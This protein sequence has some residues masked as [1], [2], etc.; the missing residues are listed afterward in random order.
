MRS[1][2]LAAAALTAVSVT[3]FRG[4]IN[5]VPFDLV[6]W[7]VALGCAAW[8][9]WDWRHH[10]SRISERAALCAV[11]ALVLLIVVLPM[12]AQMTLRAHTD[13]ALF[14]HDGALQ[15]EEA[16]RFLLHGKNP[17]QEEYTATPVARWLGGYV[18]GVPNPAL[19]HFV[20]P[21]GHLLLSTVAY[22]VVRPMLGFYDDRVV[23][24]LAYLGVL[25][26]GYRLGRTPAH[27]V[28]AVALLGLNPFFG[29][30][31]A[32]GRNDILVT[33]LLLLVFVAMDRG[34][35]GWAGAAFGFAAAV[36]PFAWV[37][38]PVFAVAAAFRGDASGIGP[39]IRAAVGPLAVAAAVFLPLVLPFVLWNPAAFYDDVWRYP[40]GTASSSY[41]IIGSG[42]SSVFIAAGW[43][44]N[45]TDYFPFW[46]PQLLLVLPA[47][48]A[49]L[50]MVARRP[51]AG[52]VALAGTVLVFLWGYA[53]RFF[54]ENHVGLVLELAALSW[55]FLTR[56]PV[57]SAT[58][59]Q[60][61]ASGG[62]QVG[63]SAR[64][65]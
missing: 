53:S 38:I 50:P 19:H 55:L 51:T 40:T 47:V 57:R 17:Y 54:T 21:P 2:L 8:V 16:V 41:P 15:M 24:L 37:F 31:L 63:S 11:G 30:Y 52:R 43:I 46:I 56:E 13:P 22:G 5:L 18:W 62:A 65:P 1:A 49:L 6:A 7:W 59:S 12:L 45:R 4:E 23:Y 34:R 42:L 3:S 14:I 44:R 20:Y 28:M 48:A 27:R 32:N 33:F 64:T 26:L 58:P 36:K 39:R 61:P 9:A 29:T 35:W 60:S 25:M 10:R